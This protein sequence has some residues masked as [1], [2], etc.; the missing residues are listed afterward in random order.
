MQPL[1][2]HGRTTS[3]IC[4]MAALLAAL[5]MSARFPPDWRAGGLS[6]PD[7]YMRLVRLR[8][9]MRGG[10]V[11]DSVARDGSGHG[12]VLHWS[13]LLDSV[14]LLLAAPFKLFLAPDDALHA[15]ALVFGPLNI[16]ALGLACVWA[17]SPFAAREW[18]F[19]GAILPA[20][21]PAIISYGMVGV[22]HHH[23]AIAVV[24]VACWGWAARLVAGHA[25]P[26]A[27]IALGTWAALGVWLSPESVPLTMMAFGALWLAWLTRPFQAGVPPDGL[28]NGLPNGLPCAI[29]L[30]GLSFAAVTSLALLADPPGA[31]I[32]ATE[33]D[34]LSLLFVGLAVAV[35]C[36]AI[37]AWAVH[38]MVP[39]RRPRIAAAGAIGLICCAVWAV[40]CHDAIVRAARLFGASTGDA[41]FVYVN[42]MLPVGG[43]FGVLQFLLT[44]IC[45]TLVGIAAAMGR[46][47]QLLGYAAV[48]LTGLLVLGQWHVRFAAY[49]EAAAAV[50]LPITL[51]MA[52][53][54]TAGWHP[55]G[56]S[57][58]R[59]AAILLF[60]QVPFMGQ[61]PVLGQL[62]EVTGPEVTGSEVT[63]SEVTGS[64]RAAPIV[65]V[66]ECAAAD[67]VAMLAPH[68]GAVVLADVND[69]PELLY[70]T[71]IRTVGSLY[72]RGIDGFLRL[73]DA[74]RAGPSATVPSE[75]DAAEVELVLGCLS[76]ARS[77]LVAD[78]PPMA[79]LLDQ[80][81]TGQPPPWLRPIDANSASGQVLYEVARTNGG[82]VHAAAN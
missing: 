68:P 43:V 62:P 78:L 23:I 73:R 29:G 42:E 60:V 20:L 33:I 17:A 10:V 52:A 21:S 35:G 49:P 27:G 12:T 82:G 58:A 67:A 41:M 16:A 31:G 57:F 75:I 22:V 80:L 74:W 40:F 32:G 25:P 71:R 19:L 46:R 54:V 9:M 36:A 45:A 15:A 11:L 61:A 77:P 30:A 66:P 4:V 34:R 53:G 5:A 28:P 14:L 51:T 69:T 81:R 18:L 2:R 72:H 65:V 7:S 1:A 44:G 26:R 38:R 6:N 48:C 55:I 56:R 8:D 59:M 79:T 64:P 24:A 3:F 13:H 39:A 47:S 63:G 76:P 50:A 70:K 37:G